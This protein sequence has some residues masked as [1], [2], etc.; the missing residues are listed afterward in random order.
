MATMAHDL[1]W[2]AVEVARGTRAG[3]RAEAAAAEP[4]IGDD[5]DAHADRTD[6]HNVTTSAPAGRLRPTSPRHP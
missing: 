4:G 1:P 5:G 3:V 2:V 6:T